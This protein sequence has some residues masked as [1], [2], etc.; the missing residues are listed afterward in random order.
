MLSRI[1]PKPHDPMPLED[2]DSAPASIV[3]RAR[4][5]LLGTETGAA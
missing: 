3:S 5:A 4:K 1:A 2:P